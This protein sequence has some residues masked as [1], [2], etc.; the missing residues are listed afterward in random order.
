MSR[1]V[2]LSSPLE[3]IC[4]VLTTCTTRKLQINSTRAF[5]SLI[6]KGTICTPELRRTCF[7][8]AR[9]ESG[10]GHE[11]W[12]SEQSNM[13]WDMECLE[14]GSVQVAV[15]YTPIQLDGRKARH[16][17]RIRGVQ[18]VG[19]QS[20]S[21]QSFSYLEYTRKHSQPAPETHSPATRPGPHVDTS[22]S[23]VSAKTTC[24]RK[25]ATEDGHL[26]TPRKVLPPLHESP[27]SPISAYP[28]RKRPNLLS[29]REYV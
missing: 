13:T 11:G 19:S 6:R 26:P 18:Q 16:R 3:D 14:T 10:C 15:R 12:D 27:S 20:M 1:G 24:S 17:M 25:S 28:A 22:L 8:P 9:T 4:T 2:Q 23:Y 5:G 21:C 7:E 29:Q